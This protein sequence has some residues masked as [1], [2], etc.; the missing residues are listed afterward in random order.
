MAGVKAGF[1][2]GPR[3]HVWGPRPISSSFQQNAIHCG[4]LG[5]RGVL[6]LSCGILWGGAGWGACHPL[7]DFVAFFPTHLATSR[8]NYLAAACAQVS[9][10]I[11]PSLA[12]AAV[13]MSLSCACC[14]AVSS[15]VPRVHVACSVHQR[16][17]RCSENVW[18]WGLHAAPKW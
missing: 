2:A 3:W 7:A 4:S 18:L 17:C 5:R 9:W 14:S 10:E 1:V 13:E 6:A 8:A 16:A 15:L 11:L 12:R